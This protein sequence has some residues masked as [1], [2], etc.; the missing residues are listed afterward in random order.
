MKLS[1]HPR[2]LLAAAALLLLP[3]GL[4]L[5]QTPSSTSKAA[6]ASL[7][8][9]LL[10]TAEPEKVFRPVRGPDGKFSMAEP[11]KVVPKG[12]LIA[13]VIFFKD[14]KADA[15]GNCNVELDFWGVRPDRST[16]QDRKG[17]ALWRNKPAPHPGFSQ[18]GSSFMKL[19]FEPK[20]LSG[21]YMLVAVAHDRIS[22][23]DSR[24]ETSFEVQ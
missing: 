19:Q 15:A 23:T 5:A 14:C 2:N 10:V 24:A 9:R 16:F 20:D 21:T 3:S 8:I 17:V 1:H 13:A 12:K 6:P 7:D 11:V 22:G 4:L 18:L